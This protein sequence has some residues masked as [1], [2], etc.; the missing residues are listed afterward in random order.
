M[1]EEFLKSQAAHKIQVLLTDG[2]VFIFRNLWELSIT[3]GAMTTSFLAYKWLKS[4]QHKRKISAVFAN[5]K[6]READDLARAKESFKHLP[7]TGLPL[8]L[9]VKNQDDNE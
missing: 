7:A 4:R 5:D 8:G 2:S 6:R 3:L 1:W 9:V